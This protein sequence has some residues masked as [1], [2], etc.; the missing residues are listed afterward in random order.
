MCCVVLLDVDGVSR[1]QLFW[2]VGGDGRVIS[3]SRCFS[4]C[5]IECVV[6]NQHIRR[7]VG[8]KERERCEVS[9]LSKCDEA[10]RKFSS[11]FREKNNK[12]LFLRLF[13]SHSV[14]FVR[15]ILLYNYIQLIKH[16]HRY[17]ICLSQRRRNKGFFIIKLVSTSFSYYLP[18]DELVCL[19]WFCCSLF[20]AFSFVSFT[21]SFS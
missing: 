8:V 12:E 9:C 10:S 5:S 2:F 6:G 14:T 13:C 19:F 4:S 15:R 1:C 16:F 17:D 20:S 11:V 21:R 3:N 18:N 7:R